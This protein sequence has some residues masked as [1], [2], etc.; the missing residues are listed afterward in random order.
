MES[1]DSG[2]FYLLIY[3]DVILD[4]SLGGERWHYW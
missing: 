1:Y 3:V 2:H 4:V